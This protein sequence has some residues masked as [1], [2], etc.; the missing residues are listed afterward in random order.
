MCYVYCDKLPLAT[1]SPRGPPTTH[2]FH[3]PKCIKK[4][5]EVPDTEGE[6]TSR[7]RVSQHRLLGAAV[8][9]PPSQDAGPGSKAGALPAGPVGGASPWRPADRGHCVLCPRWASSVGICP[10]E[11]STSTSGTRADRAASDAV[12][13]DPGGWAR[14]QQQ[15]RAGALIPL[16][17][18][19]LVI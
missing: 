1:Q 7:S 16:W 17:I 19:R 5:S 10:W 18:G 13:L 14:P 12:C 8:V 11:Q 2:H 3:P 9:A 4:I 6:P 15:A